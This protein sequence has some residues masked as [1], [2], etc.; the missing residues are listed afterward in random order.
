[1]SS[2][3]IEAVSEIHDRGVEDGFVMREGEKY[4]MVVGK[5]L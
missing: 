1:L 4:L 3:L 2:I 5:V